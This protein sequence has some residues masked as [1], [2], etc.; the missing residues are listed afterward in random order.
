MLWTIIGILVVLWLLGFIAKIG[1]ALIHIL[2]IVAV[3]L[4]IFNLI[5]GKRAS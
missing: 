5:S 3:V 4:F 1:G 2:L